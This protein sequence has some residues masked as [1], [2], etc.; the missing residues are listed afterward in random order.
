MSNDN[1]R[2]DNERDDERDDNERDGN[3]RDVDERDEATDSGEA[4]APEGAGESAPSSGLAARRKGSTHPRKSR[5]LTTS[6]AASPEMSCQGIE[7]AREP[8]NNRGSHR[9]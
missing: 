8:N 9:T 1:E 3:E 2:D 7:G 5:R 4:D 6:S